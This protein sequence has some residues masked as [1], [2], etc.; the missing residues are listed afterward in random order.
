[1][2][3][4]AVLVEKT[5][6]AGNAYVCIEVYLT[7]KVKKT[8]FLEEAEVELIKLFMANTTSGK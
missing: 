7:D 6:K 8:V 1:M 5:S 2:K 4:N 3:L